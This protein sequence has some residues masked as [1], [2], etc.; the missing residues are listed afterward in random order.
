RA[1]AREDVVAPVLGAV[2]GHQ[3]HDDGVAVLVGVGVVHGVHGV[4]F[5]DVRQAAV[6]AADDIDLDRGF[7]GP[8]PGGGPGDVARDHGFDAGRVGAQGVL[9]QYEVVL[10]E[11]EGVAGAGAAL[12]GDGVQY[13]LGPGGDVGDDDVVGGAGAEAGVDAVFQSALVVTLQVSGG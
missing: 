4:R 13:G 2:V 12:D 11:G 5:H 9:E 3:V 1:A 8:G 6:V 10:G 7:F